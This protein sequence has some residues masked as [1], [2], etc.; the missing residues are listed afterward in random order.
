M[1]TDSGVERLTP[2]D[3][4]MPKTY[5]GALLTFKA[6]QGISTVTQSLQRG[7]DRLCQQ[8]PWLSGHV[9][10]TTTASSQKLG[11]E[12]R[13]QANGKTS[14]LVDK[15]TV[16]AAYDSLSAA[17]MS[18]SS[19][20]EDVWPVPSMIDDALFPDGAPVLAA[21][22]FQFC[23]GHGEV[24]LCVCM[25]HNA[26]DATGFAEVLRLWAQNMQGAPTRPFPTMVEGRASRLS[27]A[28][29][30]DLDV[31][32]AVPLDALLMSHPEFSTTPPALPAC[33]SPCSCELFSIPVTRI[34]VVKERVAEHASAKPTTNSMLCAL[35]WS[36][37]TRVRAQRNP[38]LASETS[39]LVTAVD[40]RRQLGQDFSS[41][42]TPYVGNVVT[43][44]M[45]QQAVAGLRA[46]TGRDSGQA[47][48]SV[49]DSIAGT[50]SS[51]R[52]SLRHVSEVYSLADRVDDPTKIY[53]GWDLFGSR[54]LTITSWANLDTYSVDFGPHL[55]RPHF[56][57]VRAAQADGVGL[58]LPR[59]PASAAMGGHEE[60]LD[61]MLML[62]K[63][64][65]DALEQDT[66]W[67]WLVS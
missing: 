8:M 35:L 61:V 66:M 43:Y 3:M 58:I 65:M 42:E 39:R 37:I 64:D 53:P 44:A 40:G 29:A 67:K 30:T 11:L 59:R 4:L 17:G 31:A 50:Q 10:S 6:T 7:L 27:R 25:H 54:D 18:P 45:A 24:G 26:V 55:G 57:R 33:F 9:L 28:L 62:R 14:L 15:G 21:S 32:F 38:I 48:A 46:L 16:S 60:V 12:L 22:V 19:V 36:A 20:P 51:A 52:D 63:D 56:V 2:L 47:L 34:N 49:C 41:P 23:D 13:W 1:A 5:I